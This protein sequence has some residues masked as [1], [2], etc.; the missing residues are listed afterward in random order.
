MALASTS[1]ANA[2]PTAAYGPTP[3]NVIRMGLMTAAA[4]IPANPVPNPA[5]M[6]A[7]T[8]TINLNNISITSFFVLLFLFN[9]VGNVF[10]CLL[11]KV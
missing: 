3:K 7:T 4:P 10:V 5:P 8:Q 11:E 2:I 1:L 6:P 9:D